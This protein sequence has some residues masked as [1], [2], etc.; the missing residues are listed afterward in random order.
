VAA[1][2]YAQAEL[3]LECR[4]IYWHDF[5]PAHFL[6]AEIDKNYPTGD[7]HRMYFGEILAVRGTSPYQG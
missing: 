7:Y 2:G 1:P 3:V 5:D 6:E 4:K